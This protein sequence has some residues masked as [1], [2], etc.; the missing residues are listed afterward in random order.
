MWPKALS[1]FH[2]VLNSQHS[3]D[4]QAFPETFRA[5]CVPP[6]SSWKYFICPPRLPAWEASTQQKDAVQGWMRAVVGCSALLK[7]GLRLQR[8]HDR[9]SEVHKCRCKGR[10]WTLWTETRNRPELCGAAICAPGVLRYIL[11]SLWDIQYFIWAFFHP[12]CKR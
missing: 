5:L 11:T 6:G 7:S 12:S 10:T 3:D 9:F 1:V 2:R 4:Y 8:T